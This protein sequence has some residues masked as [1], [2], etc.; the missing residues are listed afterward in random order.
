[1]NDLNDVGTVTVSMPEPKNR[2][3]HK[4]VVGDSTNMEGVESNS[5]HLVVTS[6][7]YPMIEMWDK[8]FEKAG[9]KSYDQMHDYLT[10]TWKECYRVLVDGGIICINIGD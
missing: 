6:P 1:M 3:Q 5:V 2:T 10:K 8:M 4:I 9:A 7:P